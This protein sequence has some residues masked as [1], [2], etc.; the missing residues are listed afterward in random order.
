MVLDDGAHLVGDV[1]AASVDVGCR[2]YHEQRP[3][4]HKHKQ[5]YGCLVD[6]CQALERDKQIAEH[7]ND[8]DCNSQCTHCF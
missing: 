8:D 2:V 3:A 7:K 1:G 4:R 6:T 5:R